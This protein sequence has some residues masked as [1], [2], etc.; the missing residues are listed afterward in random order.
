MGCST[1]KTKPQ[2]GILGL[3]EGRTVCTPCA[4]VTPTPH[5]QGRRCRKGVRKVT[6]FVAD[7]GLIFVG[8]WG[9]T[10]Q[11]APCLQP[12]LDMYRPS[13][14]SFGVRGA[15][16]FQVGFDE[17]THAARHASARNVTHVAYGACIWVP[18]AAAILANQTHTHHRR[19]HDDVMGPGRCQ[20]S[21]ALC[22]TRV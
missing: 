22:C 12:I 4:P 1:I 6:G 13:S 5:P 21:V 15:V 2:L 9:E 14:T 3:G 19:N 18:A 17:N 8:Y 16:V 10:S 20:Y 11:P 7:A